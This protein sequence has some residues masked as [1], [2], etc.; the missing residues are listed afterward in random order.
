MIKLEEIVIGSQLVGLLNDS[1]ATVVAIVPAGAD[2]ITVYY[3]APSLGVGEQMLFRQDEERL[4]FAQSGTSWSFDAP[5]EEFK[6][7][8]EAY[9]IK[10]GYLFDPMMAIHSSNVDPYPHQISAVY[11][12]ML[13]KQPLRFVL[14]DD[15]GAGKTIM[16]GLLIKELLMRSDARR[17]M[18]VSPGSLTE[19]WQD[20]LL[21]K[22]NL[23]FELFS[24]EKM[25]QSASGNLFTEQDRLIVRLDQLSRAEDLQEKLRAT[26][27]DLIIVDEA[28]KMSASQYGNEVKKTKRFTLG[29]LLG[30]ITRHFLLM[31]ATPHSGKEEDFQIWLS[32]L[33]GDRFYNDRRSAMK[34]LDITDIMRRMVKEDLL[35]FDGTRLFPERKAYTVSYDLS[36]SEMRL[37]EMVTSYVV[38]EMNRAE[39]LVDSKRKGSIG[40]ALTIL[41]RRLASS[42]EAIYQSLKRRRERLEVRLKEEQ[43]RVIT[44]ARY[45]SSE[46]GEIQVLYAARTIDV[47]DN[48][49]DYDEELPPDE[50]E[51]V[52]DNVV[53]SATAAQTIE[54]LKK[55][56]ASL[57]Y[58]ESEA[59]AVVD[60]NLDCKWN[61]LSQIL[62]DRPEMRDTSGSRRKLIVFTEHRDTLNY[63]E[64]RIAN[65][66][67]TAD[68]IVTIHGGTPREKRRSAQ[69]EFRNSPSVLVLLATDAA[70]EGVNLQNANLMINYDLPWNPN[71]LEQRFG[72]IHRIGQTETCYLWNMLAHKTREGEV[73]L[74]LFNKLEIERKALGG[75]VFDILGEA[76]AEIS[77]KDLLMKAIRE[78]Q[79]PEAKRWMTEK[80]E[81]ALDTEHLK[82]IIQRNMLVDQ[83]MSL[84]ML[85]QVKEEMDRAEARKLQPCFVRSFFLDAFT[86]L[87][88]DARRR[89]A[90]RF[91][92]A[93]VPQALLESDRA[94]GE[95]RTPVLKKYERVCFE[96]ELIRQHGKPMAEFLH[97]GHPLM[98]SLTS[99]VLDRH[100]KTLK[101]GA[102][103]VDPEDEGIVP[104]LIFLIDH[105]VRE[106][107]GDVCVSRRIQFVRLR[108]DG[109]VENA[110]WA[111]HLDLL[112]AESDATKIA[113]A[114]KSEPWLS[115]RLEERAISYAASNVAQE[116]F[117]EVHGRRIQ[118]VEK[119]LNAVQERLNGAIN[120]WNHRYLELTEAV[121]AGK[122]PSLQP[123]NARQ[124][125][126]ELSARLAARR[127][128]LEQ[129]RHIVSNTP[130]IIGSILV[131]PQGLLNKTTGT[132]TFCADPVA[133]SIIEQRAM[134][135][136]MDVERAFGH[137]VFDVS[138]HKCGWDVTARPVHHEGAPLLE[139]RHIEVKGR[140]KGADTV[141][142]TRNEV[143][144][145]VNQRDKFI[146]AIVLVDGNRTDGP[147]YIR[148]FFEHEM[149][150][151]VTSQNY[152]LNEL[153]KNALK[154]EETL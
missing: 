18:I 10:L 47:P 22:F 102:V 127:K 146:L 74:T 129:M 110:G 36:P 103:M 17:V 154:P 83:T 128:E 138:A 123:L 48:P 97:P 131:I 66:L 43:D 15:P 108:P 132:G 89:E 72:R 6:L 133:R 106:S 101:P 68:A 86:R 91:E 96:K 94:F 81:S 98:L 32:L 9:R 87:G 8:L 117:Q 78:G 145:A 37:Y 122:Q 124:R 62:Q 41:Q 12:V 3:K 28:H 80:V 111:P 11:E 95:G 2:A 135:A 55:E 104:S 92:L 100:R 19:Q 116:H 85:Y 7:A 5:G 65:L 99:T 71:R 27:W 20:E 148:N 58:L 56:I 93:H 75:R 76:F 121:K 114:I 46:V 24:R 67:G 49:D 82:A 14:A 144:Y 73:F 77:L 54:E 31:T 150:V 84:E 147:F 50:Y 125:S 152:D 21:E 63:L 57:S 59:R 29:E 140:A 33:D 118:Q 42:P 137:T 141:T 34:R 107:T 130:E 136:V 115:D 44:P 109:S 16:A 149:D 35:K 142:L 64:R 30:S 105:S 70:G 153:L 40:F 4:S 69:E 151:G 119:T 79:R 39:R 112:P 51:Q 61:E 113:T 126:D 60:S 139:D 52:A 13:P 1:V 38:E 120:Y 90:G 26:E 88:G 134:S 23:K 25:E 45:D 143:C 53:D